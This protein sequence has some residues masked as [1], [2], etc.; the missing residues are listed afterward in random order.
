MPRKAYLEGPK[1]SWD[2]RYGT[3]RDMFV[4]VCS[5]YPEKGVTFISG[6]GSEEFVTHAQMFQL[7][8]ERARKL[9]HYNFGK[10]NIVIIEIEDPRSFFVAFWACILCGIIVAPVTKPTSWDPKSIKLTKLKNI[11]KTLDKPLIFIDKKY[12][13]KYQLLK[14]SCEFEGLSVISLDNLPSNLSSVKSDI[15]KS[16][17]AIIQF[18]S[19]STGEPKGV[20]LSASNIL[21]NIHALGKSFEL[22]PDDRVFSWLPHTHD[23]GLFCQFLTSFLYGCNLYIFEPS[24]F[25]RSPSLFLEKVS[26]HRGTWFGSPNFG[27]D[28]LTRKVPDALLEKL[29]LS[30]LR[31]ILSGAEPISVDV[32]ET[33][34]RK[35][36]RAKLSRDA[37]RSGYGMAEMTVAASVSNPNR[38]PGIYT[39]SRERLSDNL[40]VK[41][42][43]KNDFTRF[44]EV[45]APIEGVSIRIVNDEGDVLSHQEIG[46][47]QV[48]GACI[49]CGYVNNPQATSE[50]F[51]GSWLR[52]GDLGF[53]VDNLVVITGRKKDVLII[54]GQNYYAHDIEEMLFNFNSLKRGE[55]LVTS[56]YNY[57]EQKEQ[58]VAF[59]KFRGSIED[60]LTIRKNIIK[61]ILETVGIEISDV[62]PIS[63][64][65]KTTSG[66]LCR[67]KLKMN[68]ENGV[69]DAA[70]KKLNSQI[71]DESGLLSETSKPKEE[72]LL[73]IVSDAWVKVLGVKSTDIQPDSSFS[74]IGGTSIKAYEL[75]SEIEK[76]LNQ[77]VSTDILVEADTIEG[78][79]DYLEGKSYKLPRHVDNDK[80][81]IREKWSNRDIAITGMS[82]K[83]PKAD[84]CEQFWENLLNSV[85]CITRVSD[86]RKDLAMDPN[87]NDWLGE[88][89]NIDHFNNEFFDISEENAIFMDPQQRIVLQ[90]AFHALEDSGTIISDKVVKNIGVYSGVSSHIYFNMVLNFLKEFPNFHIPPNTM[91]GN[92]SNMISAIISHTFNFS[93]PSIA[94]DTACSSF[95]VALTQAV[96]AIRANKIDSALVIGT[97]IMINGDVHRLSKQAGIVSSTKY[98]KVFDKDADGSVL[99]EGVVVLF[100]EPLSQAEKLRKRIYGVIQG[101]ASN[102]DG[103]SLGVMAPNPAGQ[104]SVIQKAYSDAR[105]SPERIQYIEVHGTGTA[106]GDPIEMN[107]LAKTFSEYQLDPDSVAVGSVK[108]NIGHLLSAA[109]GAGMLKT[110]L[111]LH[112]KTLVPSLHM[113]NINP[114]LKL[115]SSPFYVVQKKKAWNSNEDRGPR[116]AGVSSF[117]L[118]GTNAHVVIR[119]YDNS[120]SLDRRSVLPLITFSAKTEHALD[121]MIKEAKSA[122]NG[123]AYD[124]LIDLAYTRNRFR[125]HFD[126]RATIQLDKNKSLSDCCIDY[127]KKNFKGRAKLYLDISELELNFPKINFPFEEAFLSENAK[128]ILAACNT[129]QSIDLNRCSSAENLTKLAQLSACLI[130]LSEAISVDSYFFGSSLSK[131]LNRFI[132]G[133]ISVSTFVEKLNRTMVKT[134]EISIPPRPSKREFLIKIKL[135]ED[136]SDMDTDFIFSKFIDSSY[137]NMWISKKVS[138]NKLLLEHINKIY[139]CGIDINWSNLLPVGSG[140][141]ISLPKYPFDKKT[142]W[143]TSLYKK[144]KSN[145]KRRNYYVD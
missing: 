116:Y 8:S 91:V 99:G 33:F 21:H 141:M 30:S 94:V 69:Y 121:V 68:Y 18:S 50:A 36:S 41:I 74:S 60:F 34:S 10:A 89:E 136:E 117:G 7:A 45:G 56:A 122:F 39:L 35:F 100:L 26:E 114:N 139:L 14:E 130:T 110:L 142:F 16:D 144:E 123:V 49:T 24:T 70:L 119:S 143:I 80:L 137:I 58:V 86:K 104:L 37:I 23:M 5:K 124:E 73:K 105:I 28:W 13:K 97:N 106:I 22:S 113:K 32:L 19:G 53:I 85:D 54:N 125:S 55:L 133:D 3:L 77:Y 65:P 84:T 4:D 6:D 140:L 31:F 98:T 78:M 138:L 118:G 127:G 103:R 88:L 76:G 115:N 82:A 71:R 90:E 109:G 83:L 79:V 102:N 48:A 15:A 2:E 126:Y 17:V 66:K 101:A 72:S 81:N 40:A 51:S 64:I 12:Q 131:Q 27:L 92:M 75:L 135:D 145:E 20:Q 25:L 132:S 61:T 52:T 47:I 38:F 29:D 43:S 93:G 63:Q 107:V 46:E 1:S 67:Y 134:P 11:W 96:D 128:A 112:H 59:V 44:V 129:C 120:S 95:L 62:V 108:S 57:S 111:C 42:D 87:W 9:L